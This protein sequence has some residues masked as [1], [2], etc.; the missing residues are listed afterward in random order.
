[1]S[2]DLAVIIRLVLHDDPGCRFVSFSGGGIK[3]FFSSNE[4]SFIALVDFRFLGIVSFDCPG[5]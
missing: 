3:A 5:C 1:M 4:L 2:F